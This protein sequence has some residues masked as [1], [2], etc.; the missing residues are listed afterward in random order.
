L[1]HKIRRSI[2]LERPGGYRK[3]LQHVCLSLQFRI[4]P[5]HFAIETTCFRQPRLAGAT[6][7]ALEFELATK[8]GHCGVR[9]DVGH[10]GAADDREGHIRPGDSHF[11]ARHHPSLLERGRIDQSKATSRDRGQI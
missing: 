2:R 3:K 5:L 11:S 1:I 6:F 7:Q 10:M 4:G 9:G 8:I